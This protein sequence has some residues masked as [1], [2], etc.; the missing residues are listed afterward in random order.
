MAKE[1]IR[2]RF[3]FNLKNNTNLNMLNMLFSLAFFFGVKNV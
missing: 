2:T 3:L 1:E